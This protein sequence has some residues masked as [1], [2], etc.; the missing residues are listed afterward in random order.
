MLDGIIITALGNMARVQVDGLADMQRIVGGYI[1]AVDVE[2]A[3]QTC[4]IYVNEE[5]KLESLPKND[6]ATAV[7]V[8]GKHIFAGDYIAGDVLVIGGVDDEGES[9]SIHPVAADCLLS[10]ATT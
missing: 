8:P 3:G 1:E 7:A 2:I 9:L 6:T 4:T 10:M 5:G